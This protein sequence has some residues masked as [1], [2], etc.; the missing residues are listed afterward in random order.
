MTDTV[1]PQPAQ[2][3]PD[4][5]LAIAHELHRIADDIASLE[6]SDLPKPSYVAFDMHAGSRELRSKRD[7]N[8]TVKAVD[9]LGRALLNTP[10]ELHKMGRGDSY[11]YG[12]AATLRGPIT[13]HVYDSVSIAWAKEREAAFNLAAKEA[14]LAKL[15]AEVDALRAAAL[16]P[17]DRQAAAAQLEQW[18]INNRIVV[19]EDRD[20]V[21]CDE[22]DGYREAARRELQAS[23][24]FDRS[25]VADD[26]T[27]VSPARAPWH[28]GGVVGPLDGGQLVTEPPSTDGTV[29]LC[30]A[31][32]G[33]GDGR[34]CGE[35]LVWKAAFREWQHADD[36]WR[37]HNAT[38]PVDVDATS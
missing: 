34:P 21:E 35:P 29:P 15:H 31:T 14:E 17:D 20:R 38:P 18:R 5:F 10:G 30:M 4:P 9:A 32:T 22:E 2:S 23:L 28:T 27:P 1:S 12:T 13:V 37:G 25:D 36:V 24:D 7:D 16:Q 26:P 8:V 19:G 3:E 6:G 11:H 33:T